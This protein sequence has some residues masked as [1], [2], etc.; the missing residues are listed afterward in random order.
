MILAL[1]LE[2]TLISDAYSRI[3]RPGLRAFLDPLPALFDE[4]VLF[5]AAGERETRE[6]LAEIV[7]SDHAPDWVAEIRYVD[8]GGNRSGSITKDLRRVDDDPARVLMV[9]DHPELFMEPDQAERWVPISSWDGEGE[10]DE[11]ERVLEELKR[12]VPISHQ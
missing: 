12:R 2:G 5:T 6:S 8:W 11:L 7:A 3:P 9:D 4:I 10:D 1:D